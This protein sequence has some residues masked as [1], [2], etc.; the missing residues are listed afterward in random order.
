MM[1]KP[2]YAGFFVSLICSYSVASSFRILVVHND[3]LINYRY[4]VIR[5]VGYPAWAL[6]LLSRLFPKKLAQPAH[7][8][9]ASCITATESRASSARLLDTLSRK[10]KP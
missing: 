4:R 3:C 1:R 6:D 9:V 7:P 2:A 5:I 10:S 8:Q